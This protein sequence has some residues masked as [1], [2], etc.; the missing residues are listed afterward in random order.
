MMVKSSDGPQQRRVEIGASRSRRITI[1]DAGTGRL[2]LRGGARVNTAGAILGKSHG[3]RGTA[4]VEGDPA[5]ESAFWNVDNLNVARGDVVLNR[6]GSMRTLVQPSERRK[7]AA[8]RYR[9]QA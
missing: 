5:G 3:G 4:T 8:S 7:V 1:G 9:V 6:G 2:T